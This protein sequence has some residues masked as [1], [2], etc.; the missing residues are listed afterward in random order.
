MYDDIG[1]SAI[2]KL[3]EMKTTAANMWNLNWIFIETFWTIVNAFL[4]I[5]V[6]SRL[7]C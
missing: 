7:F 5:T 3:H 2:E 6:N 4:F 1:C